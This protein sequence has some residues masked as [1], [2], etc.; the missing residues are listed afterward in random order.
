MTRR[1]GSPFV[2]KAEWPETPRIIRRIRTVA[3][4]NKFEDGPGRV[5]NDI[6]DDRS[7]R[8]AFVVF[9]LGQQR[10]AIR[11]CHCRQQNP[12]SSQWLDNPRDAARV[13]RLVPLYVITDLLV[14]RSRERNHSKDAE[15]RPLRARRCKGVSALLNGIG[16]SG[17]KSR[18]QL[19][20]KQDGVHRIKDVS[21]R[22]R[23]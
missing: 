10:D 22:R 5:G 21:G 2:V 6:A 16:C 1:K 23:C 19:G 9:A 12:R 18:S 14:E 17:R 15:G 7:E 11:R 8:P 20:D 3:P 13:S 4:A